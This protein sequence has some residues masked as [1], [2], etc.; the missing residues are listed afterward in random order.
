MS[1]VVPKPSGLGQATVRGARWTYMSL[2]FNG[3]L[4]VIVFAVLARLLPP[5]AFGLLAT[6]LIALRAGQTLVQSGIE[7]GLVWAPKVDAEHTSGIFVFSLIMGAGLTALAIAA[8]FPLGAFFGRPDL[9]PVIAALSP[10]MMVNAFGLTARG[11]LRR[12]MA[13]GQI[14]VSETLGYVIGYI[15]V[16][17]IAAAA[18]LGVYSLVLAILTQ[19]TV[20]S[21]VL[22]V[23]T[24]HAVA[25]PWRL[26]H[27]T[28]ILGFSF[29]VSGLGVL[30]YL[31]NQIPVFFTGRLL[32]M[33]ALGIYSRSYSLV[34]LPVEQIG[35]SLTRVLFSSFSRAKADPAALARAVQSSLQFLAAVVLPVALG[36]GA[37]APQITHLLLGSRWPGANTVMTA[38]C[39]G[40]AATIMANLLA[41]MSEATARIAAK[42]AIQ[43]VSSTIL[44]AGMVAMRAWGI[45]G[46]ALAFSISRVSFLTMHLV[47][48]SGQLGLT[49]WRLAAAM[50]PAAL[51]GGL[52]V[53]GLLA[54]PMAL[55]GQDSNLILALQVGAG[56]LI[57]GG[58]YL[59]GFPVF[60]RQT[61]TRLS[62]ALERRVTIGLRAVG[63]HRL[64][65][66]YA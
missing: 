13:F 19:A 61:L 36:V 10:L 5:T 57:V 8:A 23:A 7:R 45:S 56:G 48:A 18:G 59:L 51:A 14:A 20:Q 41:V 58:V 4:Q 21:I 42:A 62:P 47:L 30:E 29:K 3:V 55:H 35:T 6:A 15:V 49:P 39:V 64:R 11:L 37:A 24:R 53:G 2:A 65:S 38:L 12:A 63:L 54:L 44:I 22:L 32:G 50:G 1:D 28:P 33:Q 46:V 9:T 26:H 34:Q 66:A 25:A 40:S 17:V 43:V 27:V 60:V 31:D 16:G 52:T